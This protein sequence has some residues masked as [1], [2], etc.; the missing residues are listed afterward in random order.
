MP[1][2]PPPIWLQVGTVVLN[3]A[4]L[5][6][7]WKFLN[8]YN[9]RGRRVNLLEQELA[10]LKLSN[11]ATGDKKYPPTSPAESHSTTGSR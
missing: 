5:S 2:P 1:I 8:D 10:Q 9:E 3:F 7:K 6:W 11:K 4:A